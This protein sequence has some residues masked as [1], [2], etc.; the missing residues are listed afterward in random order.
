MKSYS[1]NIMAIFWKV[2]QKIQN[3]VEIIPI[4]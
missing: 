1:Q 3:Y 4:N 2:S